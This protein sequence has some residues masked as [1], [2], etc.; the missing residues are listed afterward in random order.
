MKYSAQCIPEQAFTKVKLN[1]TF[2]NSV[3]FGCP[4]YVLAQPM[5]DGGHQHK[6]TER[7]RIRIYLGRSPDHARNVVIVLDRTTDFVFPQYHIKLDRA[8]GTVQDKSRGNLDLNWQVNVG[9]F[10]K[11][12]PPTRPAES[13]QLTGRSH[14]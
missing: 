5:Q 10:R 11:V 2:E 6:W 1:H 12:T 14:K 13:D 3:P 7:S 9:F 8:F 4:V